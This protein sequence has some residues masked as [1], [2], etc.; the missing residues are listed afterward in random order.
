MKKVTVFCVILSLMF[1]FT[2]PII[3]E[4]SNPSKLDTSSFT[5]ILSTTIK[6]LIL[7]IT[8]ELNTNFVKESILATEKTKKDDSLPI[9]LGITIVLMTILTLN[10]TIMAN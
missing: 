7:P 3:A 2:L 8:V 5:L 4:E 10:N 9:V 6:P 1:L